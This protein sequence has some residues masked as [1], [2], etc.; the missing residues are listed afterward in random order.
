MTFDS[1]QFWILFK[2]GPV[3]KLLYMAYLKASEIKELRKFNLSFCC[4]TGN[5][6]QGANKP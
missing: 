2:L 3:T 1:V 4:R 5:V 6:S